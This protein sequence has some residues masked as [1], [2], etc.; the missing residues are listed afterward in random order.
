MVDD[1]F[2]SFFNITNF[3]STSQI[4]SSSSNVCSGNYI[5]SALPGKDA[6]VLLDLH[7]R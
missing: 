1:L 6:P 7:N 3:F 4:C 2:N 5:S